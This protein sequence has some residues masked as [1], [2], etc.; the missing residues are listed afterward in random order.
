[1]YNTDRDIGVFCC[2]SYE[3]LLQWTNFVLYYKY[4]EFIMFFENVFLEK[5]EMIV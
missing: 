4:L 5:R 1:M 2:G 3:K